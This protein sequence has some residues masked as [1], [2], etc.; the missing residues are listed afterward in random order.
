MLCQ[1]AM[2]WKKERNQSEF[3]VKRKLQA[4]SNHSLP[5][6]LHTKAFTWC[7]FLFLP[8]SDTFYFTSVRPVS[9]NLNQQLLKIV[10]V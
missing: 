3:A 9:S 2:S 1:L 10:K 8:Y 4:K 6:I 7:I 5:P